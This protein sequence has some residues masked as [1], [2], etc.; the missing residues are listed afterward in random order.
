MMYNSNINVRCE[1]YAISY[2]D[3]N[4]DIPDLPIV[5]FGHSWGHTAYP[6]CCLIILRLRLLLNARDLTELRICLNQPVNQNPAVD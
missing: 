1:D 5:L 6:V 2:V 4:E 3:S